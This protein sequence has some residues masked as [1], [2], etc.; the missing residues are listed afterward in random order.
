M[1]C[2]L[3]HPNLKIKIQRLELRLI[4][5]WMYYTALP[6]PSMFTFI[7]SSLYVPDTTASR[8]TKVE[9]FICCGKQAG[10][11]FANNGSPKSMSRDRRIIAISLLE[12]HVQK[13][14][15]VQEKLCFFTIHCNPSLANI[16]VR[17]LQSSQ[18]NVSVQLL[19]L[20]GNFL[21]NQ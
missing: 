2:I 3:Q 13:V 7:V 21:Y 11:T 8:P 6:P 9:E 15:G 16:A 19:I 12:E 4:S 20:A 5:R 14:Q 10:A 18:R 1:I 17:A